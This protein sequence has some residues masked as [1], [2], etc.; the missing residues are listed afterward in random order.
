MILIALGANLPSPKGP[1]A[2]TLR[3]VLAE[4]PGAGIMV[5]AIA[6]FYTSRAWPDAND[7][8]YINSVVRVETVH[9]PARLLAAV[10]EME[11]AFG[12]ISGPRNAPRPLD[13]DIV[14]YDGRVEEGPPA[15]PHPRLHE[16][17]FVLVPLGVIA[18][19]WRH[20]VSG[21]SVGELIDAL[22]PEA[23]ALTRLS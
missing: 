3:A 2:A 5:R 4:F 21:L 6:P 8:P 10:K 1:P 7:P 14:D 19:G 12:R 22:P 11:R 9:D 16:R 17:G 13:L 18:P 15:L 23:R 20:P